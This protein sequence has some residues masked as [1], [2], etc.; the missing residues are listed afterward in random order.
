M[1]AEEQIVREDKRELCRGAKWRNGRPR[2]CWQFAKHFVPVLLLSIKSIGSKRGSSV[3]VI[4]RR[5]KRDDVDQSLFPVMSLIAFD[6]EWGK[7][8]FDGCIAMR[9]IQRYPRWHARELHPRAL[10]PSRKLGYKPII[11]LSSLSDVAWRTRTA[12]YFCPSDSSSVGWTAD[13]QRGRRR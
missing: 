4:E 2:N 1:L 10:P 11:H 7:T 3:D 6:L 9:C 12:R 5:H 13:E 8:M